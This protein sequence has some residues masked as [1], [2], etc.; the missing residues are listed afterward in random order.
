MKKNK[1]ELTIKQ[2]R[3]RKRIAAKTMFGCEFVSVAI[4]YGVMAIVNR[5]E[6]FVENQSSWKIG[7]GGILGL[8]LMSLAVFLVGKKK[9]NNNNITNGMIAL[10]IGW[11]AVGFVFQLLAEINMEIYKIMYWGGLG[12]LGAMGL[13]VYSNKLDNEAN[14]YSESIKQ[15]QIDINKE[16]VKVEIN[17]PKKKKKDKTI[18]AVD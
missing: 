15:A 11:Y 7:L 3:N 12:L 9:E 18:V 8:A 13:N 4:P 16:Q 17:T 2:K 6:W 14:L 5:D 1:K 10:C